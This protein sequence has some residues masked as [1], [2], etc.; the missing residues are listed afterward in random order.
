[1]NKPTWASFNVATGLL[2]GT[3]TNADV[4]TTSGIVISVNDGTVTSSLSAFSISVANTNDAPVISGSPNTSV[5]EDSGYSF[6]PSVS[7]DDSGDS[8]SLSITNKPTWASF[9][10]ANG[11]LSGTPT[12]ADVGTTS[13]I[14]ISVNDGTV[15]IA[16]NA[17]SISVANTNDAPVISGSPATSVNEDSVYSFTPSVSDD[18]SGDSLSFS[19]TNKPT[20]ASFNVAT[21]LLSGT[22]TNADVGTTSGI[23]ISVNDGTVTTALSAFSISVANTND[24]PVISGSPATSVNEDSVYSFTPNV[25]DDDSGDSLSFSITNKPTWASFNVATGLLNGTPTNADVGTTSGIVIS[26]NDG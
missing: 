9:N 19:I 26:V 12:N 5:N 11:Q 18:D 22:P 25:S 20:W 7:D 14:V 17:F 8:L 10:S 4:G 15:T 16:L 6:T 3:P 23:V 1:T 24:A 13:G 2:N 21:G